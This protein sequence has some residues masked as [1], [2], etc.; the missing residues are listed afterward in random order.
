[1]REAVKLP[2]VAK[3]TPNITDI[4]EPAHFAKRGGAD[5]LSTVN[6]VSALV[7]LSMDD[8]TPAPTSLAAGP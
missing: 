6:T 2:L 7:G 5:G 1:V 4:T 8:F 3:L